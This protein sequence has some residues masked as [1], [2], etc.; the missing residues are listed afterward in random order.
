MCFKKTLESIVFPKIKIKK[1]KELA[2]NHSIRTGELSVS[3]NDHL[4]ARSGKKLQEM[5]EDKTVDYDREEVVRALEK[6]YLP[7][8]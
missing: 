2:F 7:F 4:V 3:L 5:I 6:Y 8:A 1:N